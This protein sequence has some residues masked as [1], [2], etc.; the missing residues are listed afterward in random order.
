MYPF[1]GGDGVMSDD[2]NVLNLIPSVNLILPY[3][4]PPFISGTENKAVYNLSMVSLENTK[5]ILRVLEAEYQDLYERNLTVKRLGEVLISPR[6]P[7]LGKNICYDLNIE[8]S[9][10]MDVAI[11]NLI[12]L[13]RII[14]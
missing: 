12:K 8:P 7:Y 2:E 13:E 11:E 6:Y 4:A 10:Y 14:K 1:L 5:N 3:V 9:G